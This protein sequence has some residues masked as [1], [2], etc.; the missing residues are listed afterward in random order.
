[1]TYTNGIRYPVPGTRYPEV[2]SQKLEEGKRYAVSG[3]RRR[4]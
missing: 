2:R 1:M 3:M 4:L